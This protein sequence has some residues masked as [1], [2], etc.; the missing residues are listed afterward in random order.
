MRSVELW[1]GK[2]DDTPAPPRVRLRVYDR[3]LT[4][5]HKCR[6]DIGP[7]EKWT[8]EHRI[9]ISSGGRNA[10]DNLCC[11]CSWC[12]PIKNAVDAAIKKKIAKIKA[13]H[14]GVKK[15]SRWPKRPMGGYVSNTRDI[16]EE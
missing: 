5:C 3:E 4:K 15:K 10:E 1:V 8:L 2:S 7:A 13:R 14:I 12:L 16:N 9:A 11:T 6:R